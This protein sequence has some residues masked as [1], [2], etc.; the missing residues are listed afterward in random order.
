MPDE[1]TLHAYFDG[2]LSID[3]AADVK[4]WLADNPE[5][6]ADIE[7]WRRQ[8]SA[9]R[10]RFDGVLEEKVPEDILE[11]LEDPKKISRLFPVIQIAAGVALFALGAL[12]S[13]LLIEPDINKITGTI[14]VAEQALDAHLVYVSE[15]LHP[16]E[17]EADQKAHLVKWLSKRLGHALNVP[18]LSQQNFSLI[19]GRLLPSEEG[20]AA[21]FMYEDPTG[22]RVTLYIARNPSGNETSFQLK[23]DDQTSSFFWLDPDLGYAI[24]GELDED[25]LLALAHMVYQQIEQ[26]E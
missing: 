12:S 10:S 16:V 15:K 17:V 19:G 20:P 26:G 11:L 8:N 21:Q 1:L 5:A 2:E 7:K 22:K 9:L 23:T 25:R 4:S 13:W 6:R 24:A 14:S 3:D 18:D